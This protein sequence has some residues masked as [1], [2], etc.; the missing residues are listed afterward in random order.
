MRTEVRGLCLAQLAHR[1]LDGD[2]HLPLALGAAIEVH[3]QVLAEQNRRDEAVVFLHDELAKWQ[4]TSIRDR[5]QKNINLLTLEGKPVPVLD[6]SQGIG[7]RKPLPLVGAPR[8]SRAVISLG[9][10]VPGL[11]G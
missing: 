2:P 10:L 6:V 11:Q 9:P 3:A 5:V 4:A 1:K 7:P 8:P